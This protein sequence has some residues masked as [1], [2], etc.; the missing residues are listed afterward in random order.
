M[1][2]HVLMPLVLG[3]L[4][5]P[6]A[7][8]AQGY[9]V[10][11]YSEADYAA[12]FGYTGGVGFKYPGA[13]GRYYTFGKYLGAELGNIGYDGG[14]AMPYAFA[15]TNRNLLGVGTL[16]IGDKFALFG[17]FGVA[18]SSSD[19]A[20][21]LIVPSYLGERYSDLKYGIGL[22]YNYNPNVDMRLGWD[23]YNNPGV[24][25]IYSGQNNAR[26]FSLGF[27]LKF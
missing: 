11:G 21:N 22:K 26:W 27:G 1:K 18:R 20:Q 15:S 17:K 6:F 14:P 9:D 3:S 8:S 13:S 19:F 23:L 10:Q 2:F 16:P 5:L 24:E 7:A 4:F 12:L 25:D